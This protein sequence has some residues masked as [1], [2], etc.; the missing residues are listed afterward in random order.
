MITTRPWGTFETL[1]MSEG[2]YQ[3]KRITVLPQKKLSLQFHNHRSEHWIVV[4]GEIVAQVGD[5]F[6]QLQKNQSLYIPKHV[7][8]R[9]INNT[10]KSAVLIEVQVGDYLGED[11]ITRLEDDYG[12]L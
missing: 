3:V 6:Q 5:D 7:K 11:D 9:I 1:S 4:Q 2:Q 8:H 10:S 12:R